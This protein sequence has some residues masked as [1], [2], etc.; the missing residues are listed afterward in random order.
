MLVRWYNFDGLLF[1]RQGNKKQK[2]E[3]KISVFAIDLSVIVLYY[4]HVSKNK[5][6][7]NEQKQH[8]FL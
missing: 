2:K 8:G 7:E 6:K 5:T 1:L 4:E 3:R